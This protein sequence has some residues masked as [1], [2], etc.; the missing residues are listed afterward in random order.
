MVAELF[1]D[2]LLQKIKP[3]CLIVEL[4]IGKKSDKGLKKDCRLLLITFLDT[5]AGKQLS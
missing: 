2:F 1:C 3:E 5:Y 4:P